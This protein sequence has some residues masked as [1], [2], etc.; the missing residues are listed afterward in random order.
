[1]ARSA[2]DVANQ[3][4]A[5]LGESGLASFTEDSAP[6]RRV[7]SLYE[8]TILTLLGRYDWQ[9]ARRRIELAR[10]AAGAPI[11]RWKYAYLMPAVNDKRVGIPLGVFDSL[12]ENADRVFRYRIES[13]WILCEYETVVIEYTSRLREAE[14]PGYFL[15]LA[16]EALAADFALPL[17]ESVSREA[18]HRDNAYGTS[19]RRN[20]GGLFADATRA[21]SR[22]APTRSLLDDSDPISQV[23]FGSA[24]RLGD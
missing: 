3:A 6:A 11:N 18:H 8:P 24:M 2:L 16:I 21:D 14:W 20:D 19:R 7:H 15:S 22:G 5:R 9:F 10:D 23:R 4:L 1:M 12:D 17:T 13:R